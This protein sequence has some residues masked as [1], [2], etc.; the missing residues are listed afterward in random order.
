MNTSPD[1]NRIGAV[2]SS[3]QRGVVTTEE[4][5]QKIAAAMDP[6]NYMPA[7]ELIPLPQADEAMRQVLAV[8]E[9]MEQKL[10]LALQHEGVALPDGLN[11]GLLSEEVKELA[12][13][14]RKIEAIARHRLATGAGFTETCKLIE[15]YLRERG[16][17]R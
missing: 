7:S 10:N 16:S 3:W 6:D 17:F 1:L 11:P 9:R 13:K 12:A 15:A 5:L 8:A 14:R 4:A 2:V